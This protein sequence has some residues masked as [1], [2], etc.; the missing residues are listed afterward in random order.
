MNENAKI[1]K[2]KKKE[3][4]NVEKCKNL[5]NV[6][7]TESIKNACNPRRIQL[8]KIWKFLKIKK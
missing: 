4:R 8:P 5:K 7:I 6:Q 1:V 2:I 3:R